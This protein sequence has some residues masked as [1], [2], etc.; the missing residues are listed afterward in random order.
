MKS[1]IETFVIRPYFDKK[2][3]FQNH[4]KVKNVVLFIGLPR[5]KTTSKPNFC[6]AKTP[7]D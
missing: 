2:N 7:G 3:E 1:A 5:Y 4:L 6:S